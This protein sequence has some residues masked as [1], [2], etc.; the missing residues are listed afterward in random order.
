MRTFRKK[1]NNKS[2]NTRRNNKNNRRNRS[3]RKKFKKGKRNQSGGG[4]SWLINEMS[5]DFRSLVDT[6]VPGAYTI[7]NKPW[8][9]KRNLEGK[10]FKRNMTGDPV[11]QKL[12]VDPRIKPTIN[13]LPKKLR[14]Y[15]TGK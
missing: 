8:E 11:S 4:I 2:K 7:R 13:N 14:A 12:S 15:M 3:M 9:L 5:T 6:W 1:K 10:P